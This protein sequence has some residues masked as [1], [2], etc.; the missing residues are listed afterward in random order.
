VGVVGFCQIYFLHLC[1]CDFFRLHSPLLQITL[2]GFWML[3]HPCIH[4]M[5]SFLVRVHNS[6]IAVFNFLICC[7]GFSRLCSREML[8]CISFSSSPLI[9]RTFVGQCWPHRMSWGRFL[10]LLPCKRDRKSW[11]NAPFKVWLSWPMEL[12]G[13]WGFCFGR[14]KVT[15]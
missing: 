7:W 13:P 14:S 6:F 2:A 15:T 3:K 5:T 1:S 12:C 4:G 9:S 8:A 10:P 11:C